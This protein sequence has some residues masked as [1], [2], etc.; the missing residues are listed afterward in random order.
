MKKSTLY[1][2]TALSTASFFAVLF[3]IIFCAA[4]SLAFWN[5]WMY[6]L[7]F[8]VSTTLITIYFLQND[9]ALIERRICPVE[10]RP[11]QRIGQSAAAILFLGGTVF[12]PSLAYRF[13]WSSLPPWISIFGAVAAAA[14]FAVVFLVFNVNSFASRAVEHMAGQQVISAGPYSV[15]RH[16]MYSGAV[17]V[18]FATPLALGSLFGLIPAALLVLVILLRI[19]DEEKM[20]KSEL[21]GYQEYCEKIKFKLV[22]YVW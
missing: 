9:P 11:V 8:C 6:W 10:T 20:L 1:R 7:V 19:Y 12:L 18:I 4:G 2:W 16:P 22:P 17:L 3:C 13:G 14:G 15:V 21:T 5:G